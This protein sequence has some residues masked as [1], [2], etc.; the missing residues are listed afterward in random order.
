M[1]ALERER[2]EATEEEKTH[3]INRVNIFG[4]VLLKKLAKMQNGNSKPNAFNLTTNFPGLS[5]ISSAPV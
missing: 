2:I 3:A 4:K 1:P 5:R